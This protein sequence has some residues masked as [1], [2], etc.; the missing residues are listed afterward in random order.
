MAQKEPGGTSAVLRRDIVVI[1]ASAGGVEAL[2]KLVSLLPADIPACVVVVLHVPA[3]SPSALP[4]ILSRLGRVTACHVSN[5][6]PVE[7][8]RFYVAPPN[9][10]VIFTGGRLMLS[11]GARENGH[12]PAVDPLF[13]SAAREYGPRVTAVVMSGALDDGSAGL[14][15]VMVAGGVGIVQDPEEAMYPGMPLNAMA[16][17]DVDRVLTIEQIAAFIAATA[18]QPIPDQRD[19]STGQVGQPRDAEIA[20]SRLQPDVIHDDGANPGEP[21]TYAC[22][23]CHGVLNVFDQGTFATFRCRTGH[24]WSPEALAAAQTSAVENALWVALRSLEEKASLAARMAS[25]ADG[26]G[27][28]KSA[29][30]FAEQAN[31]SRSNAELVRQLLVTWGSSSAGGEAMASL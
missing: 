4:Q 11:S 8:G 27:A 21:S 13:R 10:H 6:D 19:E 29:R 3:A 18:G 26:R 24:A 23:D 31:E 22:P 7:P 17:A 12:R 1:G 15:T 20:I 5:G 25:A 14:A 28:T 9:R 2:T 16:A 30:R